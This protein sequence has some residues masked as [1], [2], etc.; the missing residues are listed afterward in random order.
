MRFEAIEIRNFRQYKSLNF[1]FKRNSTYDLH[2]IEGSNGMG[3][4][5]ILNAIA[6]CLYGD[7]P[8]LGD[9]SRSLPKLNLDAKEQAMRLGQEFCTVSVKIYAYD[10]DVLLIYERQLPVKVSTNF[11]QEELFTVT[12]TDKSGDSKIFEKDE[13]KEYV[14]LYMPEKIREYFY[15]DGEQLHNYFITDRSTKI[16]DSI[17]AVSQVELLTS[18]KDRLGKVI[19]EKQ[20]EAGN[21][22][23]DI[24][25]LNTTKNTLLVQIEKVKQDIDELKRQISESNKVININSEYLRGQ[26]DVSEW[27]ARY[28]KLHTTLEELSIKKKLL[29]KEL[30]K[31]IRDYKIILTFYPSIKAAIEIIKEK[32]NKG[33]L[34]PDIDKKLL[35]SMLTVHKCLICDQ[36][37][38][39][40]REARIKSLI[41]QL[42]VSSTTSHMF[43]SIKSDL[44][45][46]LGLASQYPIKKDD[47]FKQ[48]KKLDHDINEMEKELAIVDKKLKSFSDKEKIVLM[49]EER[50][51]HKAL[52]E[53]NMKKLGAAEANLSELNGKMQKIET[54]LTAAL[55][56]QKECEHINKLIKFASRAQ[57]LS[58]EIEYEMMGEVREKIRERTMYYFN[59]LIWKK[60]TYDSIKLDEGYKLDLI[61]KEG[62][63]CVGSCSA[64]ERSLLALS[65]TL[66]LHE[67]SGFNALL[68]IDT[69]VA[70][71][72]DVNR[73][74]FAKVLSDV[75]RDKQIIM[76][77]APSEYSD[78]I[79]NIFEPVASNTFKLFTEDERVTGIV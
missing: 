72:S 69:P 46:I 70:R 29:A 71:V 13:A 35:E 24:G 40:E 15:F 55:S 27:E 8:H 44:E 60:D 14:N 22:N 23:P 31:F 56:K 78:E 30:N 74:N 37:L 5:N 7:E 54:D 39:S 19:L 32:E 73:E 66:A 33:L 57:S 10:N 64:A 45:R 77:F 51:H 25:K 50:E 42:Q 34:P 26:E 79:K 47:L 20:K 67:V 36:D 9:Q 62:Y 12:V 41:E 68:F 38:D 75:S 63:S 65:F 49:H 1:N 16:K 43:M 17:H 48:S 76:T 61:H 21:K 28:Q 4:T 53:T 6:W 18:I 2:I 59:K 3:K 52:L 11:E 58:E